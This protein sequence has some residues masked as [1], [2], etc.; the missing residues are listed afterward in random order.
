MPRGAIFGMRQKAT[1]PAAECIVTFATV[2]G[3]GFPPVAR[4]VFVVPCLNEE[5]T[6]PVT[7][8][9]LPV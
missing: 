8:G 5:Q 9:D 7:L 3:G 2:S 6:L 4:I 1:E